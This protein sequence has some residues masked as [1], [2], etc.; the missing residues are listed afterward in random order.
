VAWT[1]PASTGIEAF[2]IYTGVAASGG[3]QS[4]DESFNFTDS[5]R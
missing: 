2:T 3:F 4:R 5:C 1:R